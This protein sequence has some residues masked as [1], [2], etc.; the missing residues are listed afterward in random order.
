[1]K[2]SKMEWEGKTTYQKVTGFIVCRVLALREKKKKK[3]KF[4][5]KLKKKKSTKN[6]N[7]KN[8]PPKT[9]L[10]SQEEIH[11]S[12]L[13]LSMVLPISSPDHTCIL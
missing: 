5:K 6:Q 4:K 1:M 7:Q 12:G 13:G 11:F 2:N 8:N 9:T 3:K 10:I